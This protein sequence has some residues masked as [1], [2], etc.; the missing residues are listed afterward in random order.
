MQH[1]KITPLHSHGFY[2]DIQSKEYFAVRGIATTSYW[3]RSLLRML[4]KTVFIC[5]QHIIDLIC[6]KYI[7]VSATFKTVT[8]PNSTI[9]KS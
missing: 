5:L 6:H 4:L 2:L 1:S 8:K 7:A 9:S 3:E